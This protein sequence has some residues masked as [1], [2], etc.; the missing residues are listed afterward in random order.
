MILPAGAINGINDRA[1]EMPRNTAGGNHF[2]RKT[3]SCQCSARTVLWRKKCDTYLC[4]SWN[5]VADD[6]TVVSV[7]DRNFN[8]SLE[9]A[10]SCC[11]VIL[12]Q[13]KKGILD[14]YLFIGDY[15]ENSD[16]CFCS[17]FAMPQA[18]HLQQNYK[19]QWRETTRCW[20][21][22]TEKERS[23]EP[24]SS[25]VW[26]KGISGRDLATFWKP[27]VWKRYHRGA[28]TRISTITCLLQS[29]RKIFRKKELNCPLSF[30]E[31]K[32]W[33][34]QGSTKA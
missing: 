29:N 11:K 5:S 21:P 19:S 3:L 33:S 23:T 8:L 30:Q 31:V 16:R 32:C 14:R 20:T 1:D 10:S 12:R 4:K 27:E 28:G 26:E 7:S 9:F 17:W 13:G 6:M 18:S 34:L 25:K 2:H 24:K 15:S 22:I